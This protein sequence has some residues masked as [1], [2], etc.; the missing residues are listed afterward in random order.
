MFGEGT[1]L[2]VALRD[3]CRAQ[4]FQVTKEY[5]DRAPPND[6]R[7][8]TAWRTLLD[9]GAKRRFHAVCVFRTDRAFRSVKHMH[10]TLSVWQVQDI[11]FLSA[12]EAF[13]T[14]TPLGRL[15]LNLRASL[16]DVE[17]EV[18]R[19]RVKAGMEWAR[20]QGRRIGR[21]PAVTVAAWQAVEPL[22]RAG[23]I[24]ASEAAR[25]LGVSRTMIQRWLAKGAYDDIRLRAVVTMARAR[26]GRCRS[27]RVGPNPYRYAIHLLDS[28]RQVGGTRK[29]MVS[30]L[31][32]ARWGNQP[33]RRL[34]SRSA[35]GRCARWEAR[36]GSDAGPYDTSRIGPR[37]P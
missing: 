12:R 33:C 13:D 24:S 5:V 32:R 11:D 10:E 35:T 7:G 8:R 14:R 31:A 28:A 26:K 21:P 36:P 1:T 6:L 4:K 2:R 3:F 23:E 17:L 9:D 16:A 19:E 29:D 20:R 37:V 30:Q 18:L 34:R 22:A 27:H 25:R 15:L